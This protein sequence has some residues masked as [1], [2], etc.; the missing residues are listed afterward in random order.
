MRK[1]HQRLLA[2][3]QSIIVKLQ[4]LRDEKWV[5][6][7]GL[8]AWENDSL[9]PTRKSQESL[10]SQCKDNSELF[11]KLDERLRELLR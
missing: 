5:K 11:V 3:L 1:P 9:K 6:N 7:L 10:N 4:T 8:D 2:S